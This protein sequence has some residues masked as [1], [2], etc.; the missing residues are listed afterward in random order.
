VAAHELVRH[1]GLV[2]ADSVRLASFALGLLA[3]EVPVHQHASELIGLC[4]GG[5]NV[6]WVCV[7]P[8]RKLLR[9]PFPGVNLALQRAATGRPLEYWRRGFIAR[10]ARGSPGLLGRLLRCGLGSENPSDPVHGAS[11]VIWP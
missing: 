4:G 6:V 10:R 3:V 2:Q 11:L 8:K 1:V 7:I 5:L 9:V